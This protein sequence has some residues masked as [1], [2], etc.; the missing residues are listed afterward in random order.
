VPLIAVIDWTPVLLAVVTLLNT[1]ATGV[2]AA[3]VRRVDRR[4][5][6]I[7]RLQAEADGR[8]S[9]RVQ[10][11]EKGGPTVPLPKKG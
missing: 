10:A 1:I 8:A 6:R 9:A 3:W 7:D 5:A 11:D 2:L 4:T